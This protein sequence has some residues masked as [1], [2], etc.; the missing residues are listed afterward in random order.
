MATWN[1][2]EMLIPGKMQEISKEMMKY[3]IDIIALQKIRW[4]GQGWIDKPDYTLLYSGSEE[5][6]GQ[7]G[8]GFMMN[9][10]MK[11]SLLDFE[12]QNNRICK[13]RLKGR[14]RNI[15]VISAHAPTNDKDDQKKERFYE[16]V[17]ELCNRI[18][19]HD[20]VIIIIVGD[21]NEKLGN[22]E[23]LQPVA[24]PYTI[25]DS[26]NE[27]GN[28]L[29]Q[30]AIRNRLIVKSIMFPHKHIHL[31]T[32]SILVSK[33]VNQIDHVLA[34]S[35]HSSSVI[36]IR[37]CRGPNCDSD[38]YLVKIKVRERIANVWRTPRRKTRRWEDGIQRNYRKTQHREMNI[39]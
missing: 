24:G 33:E 26:S 9:K 3:K 23:Y 34:T 37:S 14:F 4:Q 5:K 19:R 2:R 13:I 20:T 31:G 18:P 22:K 6:T 7:L 30:F 21:F 16:N 36:D 25:H 27:N 11:G 38:H 39:I 29:I 1:V 10:T 28:M 17:E 15:T 35:R 32:W 12:P 8:T